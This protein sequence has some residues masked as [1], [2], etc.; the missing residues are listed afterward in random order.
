[1]TLSTKENAYASGLS[2]EIWLN[3]ALTNDIN[4]KNLMSDIAE[5]NYLLLTAKR[6]SVIEIISCVI[7]K[8]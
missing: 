1:M 4:Q 7:D 2:D 3:R 5:L 6:Q 8:L